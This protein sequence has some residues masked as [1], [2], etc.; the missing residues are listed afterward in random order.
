MENE[1]KKILIVDDADFILDSTSTLLKFEGYQVLTAEDGVKGLEL[2]FESK[3]DLILCDI[4]MPKLDGYGVLDKI[5]SNEETETTPFIFLTA[6]TEKSNMRAAMERGADDFLVKPYSRDELIAAIN[7]QW[8]KHKRF[9]RKIH[10]KV[11]EVGRSVTSAL[12]HEF[13]TVLNEV[14][15]SAKYMNS[16]YD[17]IVSDEIKELSED[18]IQSANR[19][20]KIT[21]NFLIYV[22][23]EAFAANPIKRK[24]LRNSFADEPA[25]LFVDVST[26]KSVRHNRSTDLVINENAQGVTIQISVDSFFKI[27][28]ELLDNAFRFSAPESKVIVNSWIEADKVFFKITDHG[29]GMAH[30]QI[31]RIA[32]LTQ[33]ER[34]FFEQQGLGLGLIIAKKL[35]ELHDGDFKITSTEGVG[36][37]V[38]FS[39][40]IEYPQ[41]NVEKIH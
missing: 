21:E 2:A 37:T 14:I 15:G 41:K 40:H 19:L 32:A 24:Q 18:I 31:S 28:D 5:R 16:S 11:E 22:R 23:I 1:G 20:L 9:E 8:H 3:P 27:I 34:T 36:T 10:E 4:S 13:R 39:L 25:S 30:D 33:F 38:T 7:A 12:P 35:I 29:R 26:M 17:S 6:F